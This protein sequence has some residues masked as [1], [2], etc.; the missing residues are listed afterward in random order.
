[1]ASMA[2]RYQQNLEKAAAPL[3][4]GPLIVA[5]IGAPVGA[6]SRGLS[7]EAFNVGM[8]GAGAGGGPLASGMTHGKVHQRDAKDVRLPQSFAV[9]LTATSVY[10]FKWKPF[11]GRVK[12]KRELARMP[13]EGLQ[14]TI[15]K[16]RASATTFLLVS[17][18][19]GMRTAF[20]MAT[21]GMAKA[22]AKVQ[23]VVTAFGPDI[24]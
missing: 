20:E 2:E 22:K 9:V 11:W 12:I 10:F 18:S 16:G 6:M 5:T 8:A 14:V 15:A 1:M 24:A 21:L 3:I 23:E 13:R 17:E 19:A 7:A 4:D